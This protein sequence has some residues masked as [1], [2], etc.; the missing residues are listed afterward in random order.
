MVG[1]LEMGNVAVKVLLSIMFGS[2]TKFFLNF[3]VV[4]CW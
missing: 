3:S 2:S 1:L 4:K